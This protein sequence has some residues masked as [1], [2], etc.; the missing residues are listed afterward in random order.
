[1]KKRFSI[2]MDEELV[3]RLQKMADEE[4]R[5]LSNLIEF[6]IRKAIESNR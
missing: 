3:E 6:L 5:P 2:S 4:G 1:M